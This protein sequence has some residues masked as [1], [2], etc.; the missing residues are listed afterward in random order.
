[1]NFILTLVSLVAA[2]AFSLGPEQVTKTRDVRELDETLTAALLQGDSAT[3]DAML[4]EDYI[5]TNAQG[6]VRRKPDV[7]ATVRAIASAPRSKSLGPEISVDEISVRIYGHTAILIGLTTTKYQ[8][9]EYQVLP[10]QSQL[11]APEATDRSRFLKVYSK[12]KGRWQL[13]ASQTTSIAK[14]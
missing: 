8:H 7:M 2:A 9:M 14:R 11:P 10:Q 5:E 3:V 6:L 1:M 12:L 4:A 13:V